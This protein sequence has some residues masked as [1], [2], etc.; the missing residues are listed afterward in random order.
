MDGSSTT[1]PPIMRATMIV[2]NHA[3]NWVTRPHEEQDHRHRE[4]AVADSLSD[5]GQLQHLSR[6]CN[7][8][9]VCSVGHRNQ[10]ATAG[11]P[12]SMLGDAEMC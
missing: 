6:R 7:T 8:G 4:A 2:T 9:S 3:G 11:G 5:R 12:D 1:D 10:Q